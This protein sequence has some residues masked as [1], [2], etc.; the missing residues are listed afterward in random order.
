MKRFTIARFFIL[1]FVTGILADV[2]PVPS[3]CSKAE[4]AAPIENA[5]GDADSV[6]AE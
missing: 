6:A 5:P 1:L 4:A 3:G 2:P